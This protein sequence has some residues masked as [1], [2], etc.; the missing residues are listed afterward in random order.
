MPPIYL[1]DLEIRRALSCDVA[2][3]LLDIKGAVDN[4]AVTPAIALT[5]IRN[6]LR[7]L[8]EP[9]DRDPIDKITTATWKDI[10]CL[11]AEFGV[12][13][14]GI[15]S[16]L[17]EIS[18][19]IRIIYEFSIAKRRGI[20]FPSYVEVTY[21][22]HTCGLLKVFPEGYLNLTSTL[23]CSVFKYCK[24]CW[25][26][27]IPGRLICP[28]HS[29]PSHVEKS[30]PAI[31][32]N[33][34]VKRASAE[35]KAAQ[36]QKVAFDDRIRKILSAEIQEFHA[37]SFTADILLPD[38]CRKEWL[39]KRRPQLAEMILTQE[40]DLSDE[41]I[42]ES[43]LTNFHQVSDESNAVNLAYA[44]VNSR[45]QSDPQLIWPMLLRLDSWLWVRREKSKNWGGLRVGAGRKSTR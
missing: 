12:R 30:K 21:F 10:Y 19:A 25:R 43:L 33:T 18:I 35:K 22:I 39:I 16:R 4:L 23:D 8:L 40:A 3:A 26:L 42:I 36:R 14:A 28:T 27:S 41:S 11:Y 1:D 34:E 13:S 17:M 31:A 29:S 20:D 24:Y 2:S 9:N 38:T 32:E 15:D 5:Q 45:I 6:R 44:E 37:T 7:C